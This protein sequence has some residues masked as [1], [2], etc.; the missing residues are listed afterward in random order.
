MFVDLKTACDSVDK[1][2]LVEAM[3]ERRIKRILIK[4]VEEIMKE[5]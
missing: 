5:T 3:E 2:V 4:R 1:E